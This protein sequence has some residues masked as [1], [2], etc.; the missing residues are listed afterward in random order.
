MYKCPN[1]GA[2]LNFDIASQK[3][4]CEYCLSQFTPEE[5][6]QLG[7]GK[8]VEPEEDFYEA[9]IFKCPSCGG[10]ITGLKGAML[11]YCPYCSASVMLE[12][13]TGKIKSPV[14]IIPFKLT[15]AQAAQAFTQFASKNHFAPKSFYKSHATDSFRGIYMP[16]W[17]FNATSNGPINVDEIEVLD[18][19][20]GRYDY[21]YKYKLTGNLDM[22][23]TGEIHDAA[24]NLPDEIST[25]LGVYDTKD[26]VDFHTGYMSGLYADMDDVPPEVYWSESNTNAKNAMESVI[27][28]RIKD[29]MGEDDRIKGAGTASFKT[30]IKFDI[31]TKS[32]LF[33]YPVWFMSR[34]T[35]D[36]VPRICYSAVN[37]QTGQVTGDLPVDMGRFSIQWIITSL[38]LAAVIGLLFTVRPMQLM[39]YTCLADMIAGLMYYYQCKK[40]SI[41][42][43]HFNDV[44]YLAVYNGEGKPVSSAENNKRLKD[45]TGNSASYGCLLSMFVTI[46]VF[47]TAFAGGSSAVRA[48]ISSLILSAIGLVYCAFLTLKSRKYI[49]AATALKATHGYLWLNISLLIC[50]AVRI[51]NPHG[52]LPWYIASVVAGI[53]CALSFFELI[54]A[55]NLLTSRPMPQFNRPAREGN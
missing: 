9:E 34:K 41:K 40:V 51:W 24:A 6:N 33:M 23:A 5:L 3:L 12:G 45:M 1:C 32:D 36:R 17:S 50:L 7:Q 2:E 26:I 47:F 49:Q 46:V 10:E 38:I 4:S 42:E 19:S 16:Y 39:A 25:N 11:D 13:R 14:K 55:H 21:Y 8:K 54:K 15:R 31:E 28:N 20:Q 43:Q 30:N 18:H 29:K 48:S 35:N 22:S 27:K 52:D 44:G 53:A 37:G